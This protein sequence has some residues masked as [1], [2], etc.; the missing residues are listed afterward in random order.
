MS[1]IRFNPGTVSG[2]AAGLKH[3]GRVVS[4]VSQKI[5][6]V[7]Q[8]VVEDISLISLSFD[9]SEIRK[10]LS[11]LPVDL[12][13]FAV[14]ADEAVV[15]YSEAEKKTKES[16]EELSEYQSYVLKN[17]RLAQ[18][19]SPGGINDEKKIQKPD[20]SERP[21]IELAITEVPSFADI[22]QEKYE[23][24]PV[25]DIPDG[26]FPPTILELPQLEGSIDLPVMNVPDWGV[27][28]DTEIIEVPEYYDFLGY[29][30]VPAPARESSGEALGIKADAAAPDFDWLI[31]QRAVNGEL[32]NSA[33]ISFGRVKEHI[34][35]DA[36]KG[37]ISL[38]PANADGPGI[39]LRIPVAAFIG[40]AGLLPASGRGGKEQSGAGGRETRRDAAAEIRADIKSAGAAAVIAAA[41]VPSQEHFSVYSDGQHISNITAGEILELMYIFPPDFVN[42]L[43]LR[44][45]AVHIPAPGERLEAVPKLDGF[46]SSLTRVNPGQEKELVKFICG[47]SEAGISPA[48]VL[49]IWDILPVDFVSGAVA[50]RSAERLVQLSPQAQNALRMFRTIP[51]SGGEY[52]S[53]TL[54]YGETGRADIPCAEFLSL[55]FIAPQA[56]APSESGAAF[57][58]GINDLSYIDSA[59]YD[60]SDDMALNPVQVPDLMVFNGNVLAEYKTIADSFEDV[61]PIEGLDYQDDLDVLPV[62]V[63]GVQST[64]GI[65]GDSSGDRNDIAA[66]EVQ[67]LA[68]ISGAVFGEQSAGLAPVY[69]SEFIAVNR[70]EGELPDVID[71]PSGDSAE[72]S[73]ISA[74][75]PVQD[76]DAAPASAEAGGEKVLDK[77]LLIND[78]GS[79][80]NFAKAPPER[81]VSSFDAEISPDG[82]ITL[83]A[84][85]SGPFDVSGLPPELGV[86]VGDIA[87]GGTVS[88]ADISG[89]DFFESSK[90]QILRAIEEDQSLAAPLA[91]SM[92]AAMA[93]VIINAAMANGDMLVLAE[94]ERGEGQA[95]AS[96]DTPEEEINKPVDADGVHS[97]GVHGAGTDEEAVV[98]GG[99]ILGGVIGQAVAAGKTDSQK[100]TGLREASISGKSVYPKSG[101]TIGEKNVYPVSGMTPVGKT[102][103]SSGT[104]AEEHV[105]VPQ[106]VKRY[107]N[108]PR[109]GEKA[110]PK[111][112]YSERFDIDDPNN[113]HVVT[114]YVNEKEKINVKVS[115]PYTVWIFLRRL[116]EMAISALSGSGSDDDLPR[117]VSKNIKKI[118]PEEA[119][120]ED[121]GRLS[122]YFSEWDEE[123][124]LEYVNSL[125][126]EELSPDSVVF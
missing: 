23:T 98:S 27:P 54:T 70:I 25:T 41:S 80:V 64:F 110:F 75:I 82:L 97:A 84:P 45:G 15:N 125:A 101:G 13:R 24:G 22:G 7:Y 103:Y 89:A 55:M 67:A 8:A 106:S 71:L 35:R 90:A 51:L 76:A 68:E 58:T 52:D 88:E 117:Q 108:S 14:A 91:E 50:P 17:S 34:E 72:A 61:A 63:S 81:S 6:S 20:L 99:A 42:D 10:A 126:A 49:D 37:F 32:A 69:V 113:G 5:D 114:E 118:L 11:D 87:S 2:A 29:L 112:T 124:L 4:A 43:Y 74:F 47:P 66:R 92:T 48:A 79:A 38:R 120:Y 28:E 85:V 111:Y 86:I 115:Q 73:E 116:F 83:S 122:A 16:L 53:V 39:S 95:R 21:G 123:N 121:S 96:A 56:F 40:L 59:V 107:A 109:Y 78:D 65:T 1:K 3:A 31:P 57:S 104:D 26:A 62:D 46:V 19:P 102:A 100:R 30:P 33:A 119:R 93:A 60:F 105:Y 18:P 9:L 94:E 36:R 12:E 44:A 77:I